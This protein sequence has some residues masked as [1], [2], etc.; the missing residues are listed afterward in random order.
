MRKNK[1]KNCRENQNTH[2]MF[3]NFFQ[4]ICHLWDKVEKYGRTRQGTD[5]NIIRRMRFAC[6]I[7]NGTNTHAVTILNTSNFPATMVARTR[8][9]V[10][11]HLCFLSYIT[12]TVKYFAYLSHFWHQLTTFSR[13]Q[14][15]VVTAVVTPWH[16]GMGSIKYALTAWRRS[17]AV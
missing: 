4:K 9:N 10:T 13:R 15:F 14:D 3:G 1:K 17:V 2:F 12:F 16:N 11:S 7:T 5:E 6:W 8:F